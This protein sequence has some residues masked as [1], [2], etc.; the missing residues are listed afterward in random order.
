MR[1]TGA[2]P[3]F[4]WSRY[5]ACPAPPAKWGA[6]DSLD[7]GPQ[8]GPLPVV[9]NPAT[10][11]DHRG[12]FGAARRTG[13]EREARDVRWPPLGRRSPGRGGKGNERPH[14]HTGMVRPGRPDWLLASVRTPRRTGCQATAELRC[15]DS[16]VPPPSAQLA[17]RSSGCCR[18]PAPS[19][20]LLLPPLP[21][22]TF[23]GFPA[24]R[25]ARTGHRAG[26]WSQFCC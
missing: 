17:S 12:L 7:P 18:S 16:A 25:E 24:G 15:R 6:A 19:P 2:E 3:Q 8:W 1:P 23:S 11:G 22:G 10:R 5:W 20:F 4:T 13:I 21:P 14:T 9:G 26:S